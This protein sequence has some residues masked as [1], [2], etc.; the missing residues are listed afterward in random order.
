MSEGRS[1]GPSVTHE[2]KSCF[3]AVFT[4]F[5]IS[6]GRKLNNEYKYERERIYC[7]NSVRVVSLA[8]VYTL[9]CFAQSRFICSSLFFLYLSFSPPRSVS[10]YTSLSLHQ[11]VSSSVCLNMSLAI[12]PSGHQLVS[13]SVVILINGRYEPFRASPT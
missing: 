13:L 6:K 1:V 11:S 8:E 5:E 10:C 7:P 4:K 3:I 2:L 12:C 9:L